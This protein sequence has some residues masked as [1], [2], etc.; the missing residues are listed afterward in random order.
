MARNSEPWHA[1]GAVRGR[2]WAGADCGTWY[3]Y[4]EDDRAERIRPD[5]EKI[6][7]V[8]LLE[9][10]S[11]LDG[12]AMRIRFGA[13]QSKVAAAVDS[14]SERWLLLLTRKDG[15]GCRLGKVAMAVDSE[16]WLWLFTRKGGYGY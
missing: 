12:R 5:H 1:L 4:S 15:C 6:R 14:D 10:V 3:C 2:P 11:N 16:K 13:Q 8:G 7:P 9:C